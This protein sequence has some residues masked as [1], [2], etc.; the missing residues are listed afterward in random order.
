MS[1]DCPYTDDA[2]AWA[3]NALDPSEVDRFEAHLAGCSTCR[4]EVAALRMA[5]D[6]LP[7]AAPQ[8]PPPP[9][10]KRRLMA[11]VESEAQ[12]LRAAGPD[13]DRTPAARRRRRWSIPTMRPLP[14][15]GVACALL[16]VGLG[17][18]AALRGA[19]SP[20]RRTLAIASAPSGATVKLTLSD[21]RASLDLRG[22]P[23]PPAGRVYQVWL[24]RGDAAPRPTH[25]L[26][27]VRPDGRARV[28]VDEP[29]GEDDRLIVTD[30]PPSGSKTPTGDQA[31]VAQPV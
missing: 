25:T 14:A 12:L 1:P 16:A 24:K 27:T 8:T 11:I 30:E 7:L 6:T 9:A 18:G 17:L 26:F 23:A 21:A 15:L 31:I 2:G 22:M 3:L 29:V 28:T 4:Q 10:L 20:E 5:V 13:A 19:D